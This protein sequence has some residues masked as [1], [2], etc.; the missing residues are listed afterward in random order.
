MVL[1]TNASTPG[2][3]ELPV[4]NYLRSPTTYYIFPFPHLV[5]ILCKLKLQDLRSRILSTLHCA[6]IFIINTAGMRLMS[7]T[8]FLGCCVIY[9]AL[10]SFGW[11]YSKTRP[12]KRPFLPF[13]HAGN[14]PPFLILFSFYFSQGLKSCLGRFQSHSR[15]LICHYHSA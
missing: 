15:H 7:I 14:S 1:C 8:L 4:S 12:C 9:L 11:Q 6:S 3:R 13:I 5:F 10:E 2:D